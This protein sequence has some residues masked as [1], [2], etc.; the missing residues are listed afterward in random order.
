[1]KLKLDNVFYKYP[2]SNKMALNGIKLEMTGSKLGLIGTSGSGK[3]TLI[4]LLNGMHK[5]AFGT[6]EVG[7]FTITRDSKV[8]SLQ[9]VK[10]EVAIVYQFT[11]LQ[12]F[13][14]TVQSELLFAL[15]NFEIEVED[16]DQVIEHY[17]ELFNL[18]KKILQDSPFSLSGGQKKKV[19]IITMLLI[20]P[21]LLIL[22]EPTVGLDPQSV[23]DILG[24][25]DKMVDDGLKVIMISHDMNA[26]HSFCDTI[27]ELTH[28]MKTFD[29]SAH[30]YFKLMYNKKRLL[31]LPSHLAYAA[32]IDYD[33]LL[34][35]E[36]YNGVGLEQFLKERNV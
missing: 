33:N 15:K 5:P 19:A 18:P 8:K 12:L 25:I 22:D 2:G 10:R 9:A 31:L 32:S 20:K 34:Y 16:V 27:F 11:D 14:E 23:K 24:A 7:D 6:I 36:L 29:G 28:G 30:D 35:E 4:H 26:V 3:S 13:S 1:M 17:F 21:K